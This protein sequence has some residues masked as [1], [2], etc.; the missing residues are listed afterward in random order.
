MRTLV[1]VLAGLTLALTGLSGVFAAPA[2]ERG[3][4]VLNC[5]I[6]P[7][8]S[9]SN[10]AVTRE[11]PA[12]IG[13]GELAA[14]WANGKSLP[15]VPAGR[16]YIDLPLC[17]NIAAD[18]P[19]AQLDAT[20]ACDAV[21]A[22]RVTYTQADITV[23][24]PGAVIATT[25]DVSAAMGIPVLDRETLMA[26]AGKTIGQVMRENTATRPTVAGLICAVMSNGALDCRAAATPRNARVEAEIMKF[27]S[28]FRVAVKMIDGAPAL[29]T[30]TFPV[31]AK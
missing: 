27:A 4:V 28:G 15:T 11:S 6:E 7:N 30:I 3:R 31:K 16:S 22:Q 12:G 19:S 2:T 18:P 23:I 9:T 5:K 25:Q 29:G 21:S 10:C 8:G 20:G 17:F 24:P 1:P 14:G 13:L 26:N